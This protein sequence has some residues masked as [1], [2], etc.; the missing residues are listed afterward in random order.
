[1]TEPYDGRQITR[2]FIAEEVG[3]AF[4]TIA[5]EVNENPARQAMGITAEHK[6]TTPNRSLGYE[7]LN[8]TGPTAKG[9][10][11]RLFATIQVWGKPFGTVA[12]VEVVA[13]FPDV[14]G[15]QNRKIEGAFNIPGFAVASDAN[16][17]AVR[18][19]V[20]GWVDDAVASYLTRME[21][22]KT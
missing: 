17:A 11:P 6:P 20:Q 19:L 21:R 3:A 5:A 12:T 15:L 18:A 9:D 10:R 4:A 22:L 2:T 7:V 1:M 13:E 8:L 16:A 14:G